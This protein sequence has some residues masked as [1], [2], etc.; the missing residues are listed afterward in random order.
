MRRLRLWLIVMAL[1]LAYGCL[2]CKSA[3]GA[4]TYRGSITT[5]TVGGL[6]YVLGTSL[7]QIVGEGYPN[8]K[9][10]VQT[11][12]GGLE[13]LSNVALSEADFGFSYGPE[14]AA[15]LEGTGPFEGKQ[16][17]YKELRYIFGF[18]YGGFQFVTLASSGLE[19]VGDLVG[20]RVSIGAP[21]STGATFIMPVVLAEHGVTRENS[22]F[23]LN[24]QTGG[25]E[26]LGNG[27]VE[28]CTPLART[29]MAPV[30]TLAVS[31]EIRLLTMDEAARDRS[32]EKIPG[33]YETT[34]PPN[35]YGD[36]MVNTEPIKTIG[37]PSFMLTR[38]DVDEEIVYLVTKSLF[39]NLERLHESHP[40]ASEISLEGA[41]RFSVGVPLHPGAERYYRE[42]GLIE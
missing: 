24:S 21:G 23:V 22:E 39:E 3:P 41:L 38:A 15:A 8:V 18:P 13:N 4:G 1:V 17:D 34:L 9:L 7:S 35:L 11:S 20:K 16:D 6:S 42:I 27:Q 40:E 26:A 2:G 32:I 28:A 30:A 31:K 29:P 25:A 33:A 12:G 36:K 14:L 10:T 5:G 37:V 19:T